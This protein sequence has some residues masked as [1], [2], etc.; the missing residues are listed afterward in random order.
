MQHHWTDRI[1]ARE[2]FD[3]RQWLDSLAHERRK[4]AERHIRQGQLA[5]NK[6]TQALF[7]LDP[8]RLNADQMY[9]MLSIGVQIERD[10]LG[11]ADQ[12]DITTAGGPLTEFSTLTPEEQ[13]DKLR[14]LRAQI[15]A[16]L[17]RVGTPQADDLDVD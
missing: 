3:D 5:Q 14:A 17:T 2:A 4:A 6:A 1:R 16:T 15:D 10:A 7:A 9:R 12:I 8:D 11:M 13:I